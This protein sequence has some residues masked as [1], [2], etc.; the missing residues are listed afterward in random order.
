MIERLRPL[1]SDEELEK[2]YDHQYQHNEFWD[3]AIRIRSTIEFARFVPFTKDD[4]AVA[5]LSAGD[6]AII[7][8][9]PYPNKIIGD[10]FPGFEYEGK[11][12][13]TIKQIPKVHLFI[14]SETLEHVDD[15]LGVLKAIREKTDYLLL[16]TPQD[17]W[18]DDN[19]EHYWAWDKAGVQDLLERAGFTPIQYMSEK[20]NYTH[21]YW[22]AK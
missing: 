21:Q 6:A 14:L 19:P 7:N 8:A 17:N 11:I 1:W 3:H 15:P 18:G 4:V 20:L 12:E 16:S 13:D 22:I 9:L 2:I 5:D 10:F